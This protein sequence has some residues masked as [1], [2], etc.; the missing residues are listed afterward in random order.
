MTA[1]FRLTSNGG[2]QR[3][4][5]IDATSL[6]EN[7]E[8][9]RDLAGMNGCTVSML[10]DEADVNRLRAAVQTPETTALKDQLA[11]VTN[12]LNQVKKSKETLKVLMNDMTTANRRNLSRL[13]EVRQRHAHES[14]NSN[15][16]IGNLGKEAANLKEELQRA[17]S[18]TRAAR[19][20]CDTYLRQL[21]TLRT[22]HTKLYDKH[23]TLSDSYHRIVGQNTKILATTPTPFVSFAPAL[24]F[25]LEL[26][27]KDLKAARA[28]RDAARADAQC[29]KA[30][31]TELLALWEKK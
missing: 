6:P 27:R 1:R 20:D 18:S 29:S 3:H 11:D 5:M 28:E 12:S 26:L 8:P 22:Q 24:S 19:A 15:A 23:R 31:Y 10:L 13:D 7:V 17:H 14:K 25:E 21:E 9:P 2:N 16:T 4:F 30:S